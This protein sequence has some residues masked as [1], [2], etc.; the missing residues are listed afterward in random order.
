MKMKAGLR[1]GALLFCGAVLIQGAASLVCSAADTASG[2]QNTELGEI[3]VTAEKKEERLQDVPASVTAIS[4]EALTVSNLVKLT[5]YYSEVPGLDL[6]GGIQ[7]SQILSIR[8][9]TTGGEGTTSTVGI[10]I[11]GIPFGGTSTLIVPDFDP[12]DLERIE[13]LRGPQGTL[14][15]ASGLGGLIDF[16]TVDPSFSGLSGRLEAGSDTIQNAAGLGYNF[17]ASVNIPLTETFAIRASGFT[18]EDPGYI[19]NPRL[20]VQGINVDHARGGHIAALWEPSD[21]FS[22]E[23]SALYQDI[24]G[25]GTS[26]IATQDTITKQ[27]LTDLQQG[28]VAGAGPYERQVQAYSLSI[29]EKIAG[30]N[31]ASLTGFNISTLRD[32]FD[33]TDILGFL[34]EKTFGVQGEPTLDINKNSR[35]VEELRLT[36]TIGQKVERPIGG[37]YSDEY[38]PYTQVL[39]ATNPQTGAV[40]GQ[41]LYAGNIDPLARIIQYAGFGTATFHLTDRFDVQ[42]GG[43]ESFYLTTASAGGIFAGPYVPAE[44][45]IPSPLLT[46]LTSRYTDN[47]ATYLL[48]PRFKISP[49][50]MVYAR[51]ATGFRPGGLTGFVNIPGI[52]TSFKPDKTSNYEIGAKGDLLD[53]ALSFDAAIYYIDWKDIQLGLTNPQNGIQYT[54]NGAKAKSQGVEL[55]VES[56]PAQGLKLAGW[57]V[58]SDAELTQ[59]FPPISVGQPTGLAGDQLPYSSRFSGNLSVD[60]QFPL[61]DR[62]TGF[63]GAL[64]SYIGDRRDTFTD[65]TAV[66]VTDTCTAAPARQNLPGYAKLD[67]RSGVKYDTWTVN[68]YVNNAA[69]RRGVLSGGVGNTIPYSFYLIQPRTIGLNLTKIF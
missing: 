29:N 40:A 19:D 41:L 50:L 3:V 33:Y 5:D 46:G 47:A 31:I 61:G 14:Y 26:D 13:V 11:D 69:N 65:C 16:V 54:G 22:V 15:G 32:S 7:S 18:R 59:S 12:G 24:K 51:F 28:Y 56:H 53:H 52:P 66:T 34:S 20:N 1:R 60:Q 48:T 58:I 37:F 10:L 63:V 44:I 67:L 30:F 38:G 49:D 55:S 17:R 2:A 36:T 57:I 25:D 64:E 39:E 6:V 62:T 68:L 21:T 45:G 4:A 35:I 42:A 8:G 23:L 9:I 43:R 27:P